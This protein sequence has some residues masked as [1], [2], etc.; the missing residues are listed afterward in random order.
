MTGMGALEVGGEP[1]RLYVAEAAGQD[2]PGVAL[3]HAWWG[4]N[5]D[6]IGFADR[7]AAAGLHVVAPDLY[8]GEVTASIDEAD[9]LSSAIDQDAVNAIALAAIDRLA[10]R[11]GAGT[12][13]GTVGFSFGAAWAVWTAGRRDQVGA[14]VVYYGSVTGPTLAAGRSAVVGHFAEEDPYETAEDVAAFEQGLRDA[15]REVTIHR[16]P[17]TGHWFAEPSR[18]AYRPEAAELAFDRT[19]E[20]LR[21]ELTAGG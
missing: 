15:G 18:D 16:Y 13:I 12:R 6:V 14:S 8:R 20:F 21:R 19:V 17:G 2:A 7:L 10:E 11:E 1:V 4:L 3:Y 9:R 5:D